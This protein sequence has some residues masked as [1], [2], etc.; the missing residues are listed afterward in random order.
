M[1]DW[2][3]YIFNDSFATSQNKWD[4]KITMNGDQV[5]KGMDGDDRG[6]ISTAADVSWDS[7]TSK[8]LHNSQLPAVHSKWVVSACKIDHCRY[9]SYVELLLSGMAVPV[10][11]LRAHDTLYVERKATATDTPKVCDRG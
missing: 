9:N 4:E 11:A 6:L 10:T 8:R 5:R 1:T 3:G 7:E 2:L